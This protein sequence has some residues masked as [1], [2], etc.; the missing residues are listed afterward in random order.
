M[1]ETAPDIQHIA[2]PPESWK[3]PSEND[4]ELNHLRKIVGHESVNALIHYGIGNRHEDK[5]S[6]VEIAAYNLELYRA[7]ALAHKG[8]IIV[9]LE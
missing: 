1:S 3:S 9:G 2:M 6:S 4:G 8:R 5:R 7:L